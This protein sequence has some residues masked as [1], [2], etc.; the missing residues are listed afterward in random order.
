MFQLPLLPLWLFP[1]FFAY[2]A[3]EL[4]RL[5]LCGRGLPVT[6]SKVRW[7]NMAGRT[8]AAA[9]VASGGITFLGFAQI[10]WDPN[11]QC[12]HDKIVGTVVVAEGEARVPGDWEGEWRKRTK[13]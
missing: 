3:L 1:L 13:S 5:G 7:K 10:L 4:G 2:K 8:C 6:S 9:L 11:R 12:I